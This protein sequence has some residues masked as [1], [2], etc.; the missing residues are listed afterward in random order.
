MALSEDQ[1][2]SIQT[3]MRVSN[4]GQILF[5]DN[6]VDKEDRIDLQDGVVSGVIWKDRSS[7]MMMLMRERIALK[8]AGSG[9]QD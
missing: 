2:K 9:N 5:L 6:V 3:F 1:L 7:D 8:E 4:G